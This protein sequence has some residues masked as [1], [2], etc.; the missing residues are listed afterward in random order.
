MKK[1][2]QTLKGFR[3]IFPQEKRQRDYVLNKITK[4]LQL[5]AFEPMET[6]TLEY[7]DLLLGKYGAETDKLVYTFTDQ[8]ERQLGLRYDQTVPTARI[9]A[10]YQN[11]LPKFFRRY[12]IQ[13]VFRAEKPQKGRFREFTQCDFDIFGSNSNLADAEILACA[14]QAY[15]NIGF[16]NIKI[17]VNDKKSLVAALKPFTTK[18]VSVYDIIQSL[19]KIE[20]T[21]VQKVVDDLTR[22]GLSPEVAQKIIDTAQSLPPSKQLQEII[23]QTIILGVKKQNL[24]YSPLLARGLDYYTDMICEVKIADYPSGSVGG[25]GRYNNLI[26]D[27]GGIKIPAVGFSFGFDRTAEAAAA[28]NLIPKSQSSSQVLV[29]IFDKNFIPDS[30][31]IVKQLRQAD[32]AVELYLS[33]DKLGKQLSLANQKNIPFTIVVGDQ[34]K[35]SSQ[36]SLKNMKTG[37]QQ[38][39]TIEQ[40]IEKLTTNGENSE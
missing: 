18:K 28:L 12:Q 8:G 24:I 27:L 26:E 17:L 39:L 35:Q 25:G 10:Q 7:A 2:L 13:N 30:L 38:L 9:L 22:K 5:F 15:A 37:E 31:E 32:I 19:D 4:V 21:T 3:D 16:D 23:D 34:E 1:N 14:Y 36:V 20:K 11:N 29:T 40:V 33:P 6:P